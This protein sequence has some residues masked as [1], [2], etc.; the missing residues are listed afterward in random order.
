MEPEQILASVVKQQQ[1]H[2][3]ALR[4]ALVRADATEVSIVRNMR[5]SEEHIA[6]RE[7]EARTLAERGDDTGAKAALYRPDDASEAARKAPGGR[8]RCGT[9][10]SYCG[11]RG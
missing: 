7:Q 5:T 10:R 3:D 8:G 11:S 4:T 1:E 6:R 2:I 9:V